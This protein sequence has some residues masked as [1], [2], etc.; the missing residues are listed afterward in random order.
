M[1]YCS[2]SIASVGPSTLPNAKNKPQIH[3]IHHDAEIFQDLKQESHYRVRNKTHETNDVSDIEGSRPKTTKERNYLSNPLNI[4]DIDGAR[5]RFKDRFLLTERH[6]NPLQPEYRLPSAETA[7]IDPPPL[8]RDS[9]MIDDIDGTRTSQRK[10]LSER[11][12]LQ[13]DD[14]EGTRPG[15]KPRHMRVRKEAQPHD[16]LPLTEN[17]IKRTFAREA[18]RQTDPLNPSYMIHHTRHD[19]IEKSKPKKS[20]EFITDNHFLKTSD[21]DG[22]Q[23]GYRLEHQLSLPNTLR[24]D[25][26]NTNYIG[27]IIGAQADT[28]KTTFHTT[29]QTNP[30]QPVYQSLDRDHQGDSWICGP[31]E[32]L[33]PE[34][35]V[36]RD[37]TLF[38]SFGKIP[39]N[40]WNSSK[41]L[42]EAA[43]NSSSNAKASNY[44][45]SSHGEQKNDDTNYDSIQFFNQ[46]SA[47]TSQYLSLSRPDSRRN[48]GE[49]EAKSY[50]EKL[51]KAS[52][53]LDVN[54]NNPIAERE[55]HHSHFN[56]L[57]RSTMR[58]QSANSTIPKSSRHSTPSLSARRQE[59]P[60]SRTNSGRKV[61]DRASS[62]QKAEL[63]AEILAIR[64]L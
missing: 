54:N 20:K 17:P 22:A 1:E 42:R 24:K 28:K 12:N 30:L 9:L 34:K 57:P 40:E 62:R 13:L 26:K 37:T 63:E 3:Y 52:L 4:D 33:V 6:V 45:Q 11:D 5:A 38:K 29:R 61:N 51:V 53:M 46:S 50:A 16:I 15:W 32:S 49:G 7:P 64:D 60:S 58:S 56:S 35:L 23:V 14:I 31:V 48:S 55:T 2:M 21:I 43:F 47:T 59:Q 36:V 44:L 27:D 41:H 25:F 19:E 8:R 18:T 39:G 10:I